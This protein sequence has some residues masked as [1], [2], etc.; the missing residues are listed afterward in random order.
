[1]MQVLAY[2]VIALSFNTSPAN[3]CAWDFDEKRCKG[4]CSGGGW[5]SRCMHTHGVGCMCSVVNDFPDLHA[6]SSSDPEYM[7]GGTLSLSF[8]AC[9]GRSTHAKVD[10][11]TPDTLQLGQQ[12]RLTVSGTVDEV[13]TGA[14]AVIDVMGLH[15]TIEDACVAKTVDTK[16]GSLT[17]EG[18]S[19]PL[20]AG[21]FSLHVDVTPPGRLP[22]F[23]R[24]VTVKVEV[25]STTGDSLLCIDI[26]ARRLSDPSTVMV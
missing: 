26:H 10:S 21:E 25:T 20:A 16:F 5:F 23:L 17:F 14:S 3:A 6:N 7:Q 9:Q 15:K 2:V 24:R 1:M 13:V 18:L 11:L 19:C 8:E 22:I 12:N 4:D